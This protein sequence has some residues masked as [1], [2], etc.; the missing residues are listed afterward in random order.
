MRFACRILPEEE[1]VH[2]GSAV[3]EVECL[4]PNVFQWTYS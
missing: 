4:A 2:N 3:I 1:H